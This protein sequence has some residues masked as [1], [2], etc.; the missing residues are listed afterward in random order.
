MSYINTNI[1]LYLV[2]QK[3][4]Y[5]DDIKVFAI[6]NPQFVVDLKVISFVDLLEK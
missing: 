3:V 6:Y 5:F 4:A 2:T 1:L